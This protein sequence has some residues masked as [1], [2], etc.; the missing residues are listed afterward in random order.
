MLY[1]PLSCDPPGNFEHLIAIARG[2]SAAALGELLQMCRP[3]LLLLANAELAPQLQRK[4]GASDMVQE[5]FLEAHRDFQAFAGKTH[6]E[7]LGWLRRMLLNNLSNA[8]RSFLD[9]EKRRVQKEQALAAGPSGA[10]VNEPAD[11]TCSPPAEL[12]ARE[13]AEKLEQAL[14]RIPENYQQVIRLRQQENRTFAEIGA[15]MSCSADAARML[16][17]RAI[18]RL[19]QEFGDSGP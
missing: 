9:T 16:W 15:D 3:Y 12:I 14:S 17:G 11:G 18:E 4:V 6:E 13:Q 1:Q 2:G 19:R 7:L 5:T 8:S 10:M